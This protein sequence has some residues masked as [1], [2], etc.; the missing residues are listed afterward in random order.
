MLVYFG[1][2]EAIVFQCAKTSVITQL[3]QKHT[4]YFN[5]VHCMAHRT[6][7]VVAI[8]SSLKLISKVESLLTGMYNYFAHNL[9]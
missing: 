1:A 3:M 8:L 6:N 9:K 2:N 4:P 7:L 5:S